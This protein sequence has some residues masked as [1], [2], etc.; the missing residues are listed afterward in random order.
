MHQ[1]GLFIDEGIE[2]ADLIFD[3]ESDVVSFEEFSILFFEFL[4]HQIDESGFTSSV[5][6]EMRNGLLLTHVESKTSFDHLLNVF[7][8]FGCEFPSF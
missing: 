4:P 6:R 8:F 7:D 5:Q 2:Y 3:S 1:F